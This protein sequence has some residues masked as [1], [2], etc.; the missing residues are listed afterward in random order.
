MKTICER[1]ELSESDNVVEIGTGWGGL[2]IFMA[3]HYG[4]HVTT[5]TI[6]DAQHELAEQ[7][8]K[9]LGLTD[10]ITLLKEDYRNLTGEYDKLVSIEMIGSGRARISTN[11]LWKVLFLCW[12]LQERCWFKRSPLPTVVMINTVKAS[13]LFRSTSS[14]WLFTS[15]AR[16]TQ[17]LCDQHRPCRPRNWW[18]WPTLRSNTQR[19]EPGLWKQLQRAR[20]ARGYSEEFKRLGLLL[21]YC[22]R[23]IPRARDQHSS[24]CRKKT[25]LLW[26]KR[27]N[28][29]GLLI[30]FCFK[31]PGFAAPSLPRKPPFV[32][33]LIVVVH[34]LLS[35]ILRS[36]D[37]KIL[38]SYY[39]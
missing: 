12:S 18:H 7:R 2:A 23:S 16:M 10:K 29:S 1:L 14:R 32:T 38:S 4:R 3:Q 6:S 5:M 9:A 27:W 24:P 8:V 13:T 33:P 26:S 17:H 15:V 39:H 35:P 28:G 20:T 11:L 30:S 19:L 36:S 34:F 21:G 25:S 37:L 31:R 22:E